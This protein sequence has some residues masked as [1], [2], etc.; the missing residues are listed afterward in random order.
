MHRRLLWVLVFS[1]IVL[2]VPTTAAEEAPVSV[3]T[4]WSA[5]RVHPGDAV[6][7]AVVIEVRDGYHV[8]ADE[9]QARGVR[10]FK[11]FYTRVRLLEASG[12]IQAESPRYPRASP[13]KAGYVE[14]SVMTFEGR[15]VVLI[16]I[17]LDAGTPTGT[18]AVTL[19]V[20]YQA[21]GADFCEIPQK[22]VLKAA[23]PV[24]PEGTPTAA[25]HPDLFPESGTPTGGGRPEW[26]RFDLFGWGF[27]LDA[28]SLAGLTLLLLTAAFGGLLLNCTPCVLPLVPI[29]VISMS[30]AASH[31]GRCAA[32]G[33]STFLGVTAF[34]LALGGLV[35]AVS[36]F[37][38]PNQLF[39]Y[40]IFTIAVGAVIAAMAAT[41]FGGRS[42][43]LPN[44]IYSF[45]PAQETLGGAFGIGVLTAV[46]ST[47]C[48]APFMGAAA[49]WAVTQTPATTLI[50]FL[51]VGIGMGAPYLVL[52]AFPRIVRRVPRSGPA[53]ELLKQAM[54]IFMLA[55]AAYFIGTGLSTL[56]AEPAAPPSRLYWWPVM[57]LCALAGA[58]AGPRAARL[59]TG[60]IRK[61]A[62]ITMGV[63]VLAASI[64]GAW[65]LTD[66]G[67]IAWVYYTPQRLDE[68]YKEH[69]P[70]VLVF[71]AEWCL[72]CKAL[73]QSVWKDRELADLMSRAG[74]VPMK[75]DLTGSNPAG[76]DKLRQAGSLTIPFLTVLDRDGHPVFSGDYYTAGQVMEAIR[77]TMERKSF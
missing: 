55:G 41:L 19:G 67:P 43:R 37:T 21:C 31:R 63:L 57:G 59:S 69:R 40:P 44:F 70:V 56:A 66:S 47:P 77:K 27:S 50:T 28:S 29:K 48:T 71:T 35:S 74:V 60:N 1:M 68:A 72:N 15:T 75:V 26:V 73:E 34:W 32:L 46:L 12:G 14:D 33:A 23:L 39:R 36:G 30:R 53:S 9:A 7:L 2:P 65:R 62:W 3:H 16:P 52:A 20:E 22:L 24:V 4:A 76:K 18:A 13:L 42:M 61:A 6:T 54:A 64:A 5:D 10:G 58:W 38:T 45:N 51:A 11:P 17:R 49:A 8:I 25:T